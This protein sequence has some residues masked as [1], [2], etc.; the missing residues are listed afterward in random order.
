MG[1]HIV[2]MVVGNSN[3]KNSDLRSALGQRSLHKVILNKHGMKGPATHKRKSQST[4]INGIWTS[5]GLTIEK[6]GYFEYNEVIP[7]DHRCLWVDL[8]FESAFGHN[9][10]P[11][12]KQTPKR[13]HCKDPRLVDNFVTLYHQFACPLQLFKQVQGLE[14]NSPFMSRYECRKLRTSQVAFSPELNASRRRIQARLLL[15]SR[16][17]KKKV[18]SRLLDRSLKKANMPSDLN[19]LQETDFQQELKEEYQN[20]YS[21]KGNAKQLR[22]TALENLA[23]ALAQKGD[24]TKEK[25]LKALR[26]REQQ[27]QTARKIRYLQGKLRIGSTTMV[28]TTDPGGNRVDITDQEGIEQAI[29][30][31]N[32]EKFR[33]SSHTPFYQSPLKDDFGF[34]GLTTNVQAALA[35]LNEPNQEVDAKI[36][37]VIAQWQIPQAVRDLGSL[38]MEISLESYVSFWKKARED[39]SC[40]PSSL[41]FSTMK[42]GATDT[43]I[44][45]LDCTMTRLPLRYGYAPQCW[46]HCLDV[47]I[48]KKSGVTDLSV[49]HTI[50]LFPVDCNF[51]FKHVGR[52]MMAV[53]EKTGVHPT[54]TKKSWGHMFKRC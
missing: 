51:A 12:N 2:L 15:L 13:L 31:S 25:M 40:Y 34:K 37:D 27:R 33:Q 6:C 21:I 43:D 8:S 47:M 52:S 53:A 49:L 28:T 14:Q 20:Y 1:D 54:S 35:G 44:A 10:P 11:L 5:Q 19:R 45:A 4:P 50:V 39:T 42:A 32:E 26:E 29:L 16:A 24:S 38:K 22:A 23:E 17:Q 30:K 18:S 46:K 7:S 48:M 36:L 9:M 41:S 3:M